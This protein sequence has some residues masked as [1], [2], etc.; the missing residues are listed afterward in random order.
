MK[1]FL[2]Q[3]TLVFFMF[4]LISSLFGQKQQGFKKADRILNRLISKAKV[5]GISVSVSKNGI[6]KYS[7]GFGFADLENKTPVL[8]NKTI[9]RVGSISKPIAASGLA[10]MVVKNQINLNGFVSDYISYFPKKKYDFTIKQLGG[11]LA[12]IRNYKGNEFINKLPLT[13]KNGVELFQNDPLL[14]PPGKDYLYTSYSWNLLSLAM[15]EVARVPFEDIIK[16]E[17]LVPLNMKNTFADKNQN[18][19]GKA[20][21]YSKKIGSGFVKSVYVDN[22]YKL[23]GGGY[24]STSEDILKLGNAYLNNDYL[25]NAT[26][27]EFTVSQQI[28]DKPTY[29]GIGW[30]SSF[31]HNKR[32]YFG[33][34]GNGLG[35]YGIFYVYPKNNIV[36]SVLMNCSNPK[37]D[38]KFRKLIDAF[39][40]ELNNEVTERSIL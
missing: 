20:V 22:Y 24:L 27:K 5:P 19:S 28:K 29:Y 12:G 38:K 36:V 23:A 32:P 25:G 35:G 39:F 13:I 21:F 18:I 7:K 2:K 26:K 34:I 30:Q 37:L 16:G 31:D 8:P 9:F 1:L 11:H 33:H 17:V 4:S 10:Q 40:E 3:I 6:T 14:F 15:Q